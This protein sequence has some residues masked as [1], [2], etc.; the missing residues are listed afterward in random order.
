MDKSVK[1]ICI[2]SEYNGDK[3]VILRCLLSRTNIVYPITLCFILCLL[4]LMATTGL[5][6]ET[7]RNHPYDV[8]F[9][10]QTP[11]W[12]KK[13]THQ[14]LASAHRKFA[15]LFGAKPAFD[16]PVMV[17]FRNKGFR[18]SG[19]V[20]TRK[21]M[22]LDLSGRIWT[23]KHHREAS[24][25]LIQLIWHE[26]FHIWHEVYFPQINRGPVDF[27]TEGAA[28]YFY[29]KHAPKPQNKS[30]SAKWLN[31][32]SRSL[33]ERSLVEVSET[34]L[35]KANYKC[36]MFLNWMI[37]QSL[38][39]QENPSSVD[40]IWRTVFQKKLSKNPL[41]NILLDRFKTE[42]TSKTPTP[43][44]AKIINEFVYGT[45]QDR[46]THFANHMQE[47][48]IPIRLKKLDEYNSDLLIE[49]MIRATL[50]NDC[51]NQSHWMLIDGKVVNIK[52]DQCQD[53]TNF[54]HVDTING[55][56]VPDRA[57]DAFKMI[58]QA[59]QDGET[60]KLGKTIRGKKSAQEL[61]LSCKNTL[62]RPPVEF[63]YTG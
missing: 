45:G 19:N 24:N 63:V 38:T 33:G 27:L 61:V 60:V 36:G 49:L 23:T 57:S 20:K 8:I 6:A 13:N 46:W 55:I 30:D 3:G 9:S 40:Q 51:A 16:I 59:C 47:I 39:A 42:I 2:S 53:L 31:A 32:C 11:A 12:I 21:G 25:L 5:Q 29:W 17:N 15:T 56:D 50:E 62:D 22:T 35:A 34:A 26:S 28:E 41:E 54:N 7:R 58:R 37:D 4:T 52:P 1:N 43:F 14:Q 44:T 48:N 10:D 18:S